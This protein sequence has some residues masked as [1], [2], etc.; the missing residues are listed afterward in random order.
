LD[1]F[2]RCDFASLKFGVFVFSLSFFFF[3]LCSIDLRIGSARVEWILFQTHRDVNCP[4]RRQFEQLRPS[5]NCNRSLWLIAN[6]L[7]TRFF[8]SFYHGVGASRVSA[9]V[10]SGVAILIWIWS[11]N[12]WLWSNDCFSLFHF[13]NVIIMS[14]VSLAAD[15]ASMR[16]E[17]HAENFGSFCVCSFPGCV[18]MCHF[19]TCW[20]QAW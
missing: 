20:W 14:C 4:V 8:E 12:G 19:C 10:G 9:C 16:C 7:P 13:P 2:E 17:N 11:T 1:L 15:R 3:D 5:K 6:R 18:L